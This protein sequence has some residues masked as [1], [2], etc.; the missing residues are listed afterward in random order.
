MKKRTD[1]FSS[2]IFSFV[3]SIVLK[4]LQNI[5]LTKYRKAQITQNLAVG[6]FT[7]LFL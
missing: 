5:L 1:T 6:Y 3:A 7:N 2:V 4:Y